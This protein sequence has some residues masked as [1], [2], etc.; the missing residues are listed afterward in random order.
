MSSENKIQEVKFS[1]KKKK[2]KARKDNCLLSILQWI[3]YR[4]L[5]NLRSFQSSFE[6][7]NMD[8][9]T[10]N[11]FPLGNSL[12]VYGRRSFLGH[13][14]YIH[15]RWSGAGPF[16][17]MYHVV[18][19]IWSNM[20]LLWFL[21]YQGAY[22]DSKIEQLYSPLLYCR[23]PVMSA[24][25]SILL[26]RSAAAQDLLYDEIIC[27]CTVLFLELQIQATV[28]NWTMWKSLTSFSSVFGNFSHHHS[29]PSLETDWSTSFF[30]LF[31]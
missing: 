7:S 2:K 5:P 12:Q 14:S 20:E 24:K 15:C 13:V 21:L 19:M 9:F 4:A 29:F 30:C 31:H 27:S 23:H 25:G 16:L 26:Q 22:Q 6:T 28:R 10:A 18:Q 1:D 17:V 3:P 8:F 11:D